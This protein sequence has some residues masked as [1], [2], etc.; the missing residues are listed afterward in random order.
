MEYKGYICLPS[1]E[2]GDPYDVMGW[3][4]DLGDRLKYF[5][6]TFLKVKF[7]KKFPK[8]SQ[9][10]FVG[11]M[12][13][14]AHWERAWMEKVLEKV[15]KYPQHIFM[16]LTQDPEVYAWYLFG[17]NCWLGVTVTKNKEIKKIRYITIKRIKFLSIEPILERIDI[18]T[19]DNFE[20]NW[21]IVGAETG[22]R[23]GK[24]I[25]EKEWIEVIVD[26]C[27]RTGVPLYLKD[28]LKDIYPDEI[29]EFPKGVKRDEFI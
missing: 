8:K 5:I 17:P 28:S 19:I 1:G 20:P 4:H 18:E 26:F 29:K 11:S 24:V 23:K 12:S 6:P 10:I 13:E 15:K 2:D 22:N 9:R 14:I 3:I 21:I 27:N 7:N 25:P 16:F